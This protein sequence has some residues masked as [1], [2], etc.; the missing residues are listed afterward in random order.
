MLYH[1][2]VILKCILLL[3]KLNVCLPAK[4]MHICSQVK[5][6]EFFQMCTEQSTPFSIKYNMQVWFP[7]IWKR[8]TRAIVLE[9]LQLLTTLNLTPDTEQNE[10]RGKALDLGVPRQLLHGV[11]MEDLHALVQ[12]L[13]RKNN[14]IG[15]KHP[16]RESPSYDSVV[17]SAPKSNLTDLSESQQKNSHPRE[18][19]EPPCP[20][21][22]SN[23]M[24]PWQNQQTY[25]CPSP[26]NINWISH[27]Y[28]GPNV[29]NH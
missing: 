23:S 11:P 19:S 2:Q 13:T 12:S 7:T 26:N 14:S 24:A 9:V 28:R 6:S 21:G 8:T 27:R 1:I 17:P 20:T 22:T 4:Q 3:G 25:Y 10:L 16:A 29:G 18:G 15:I 5:P